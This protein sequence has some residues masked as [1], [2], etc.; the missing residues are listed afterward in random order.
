MELEDGGAAGVAGAFDD[1]A[2]DFLGGEPGEAGEL[3]HDLGP[4]HEQGRVVDGAAGAVVQ[5]LRGVGFENEVAPGAQAGGGAGVNLAAQVGR[6]VAEDGDHGVP[7]AGGD[8]EGGEVGGE[9]GDAHT[10][11]GGEFAG[12]GEAGGALVDGGDSVAEAG[13]VDGVATFALSQAEHLGLGRQ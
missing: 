13:E 11:L 10:M 1:V 4:A 9:G 2:L 6:Q 8:G 12:L 3:S 5:L 7:S